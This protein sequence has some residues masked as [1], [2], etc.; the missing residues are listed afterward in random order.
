MSVAI[1]KGAG[2]LLPDALDGSVFRTGQTPGEACARAGASLSDSAPNRRS[3]GFRVALALLLPVF[4]FFCVWIPGGWGDAAGQQIGKSSI[5]EITCSSDE[6][7]ARVVV[8]LDRRVSYRVGRLGADPQ[9]GKPPRIYV[10]MEETLC[11]PSLTTPYEFEVGP[12]ERVRA[13][14]FDPKTSRMVLDLRQM[15]D[16]KVVGMTDPDRIVVD[17]WRIKDHEPE[18]APPNEVPRQRGEARSEPARRMP[19]VVLD[20]GHGGHDP[21]AVGPRGLEEK[22][23]VLD[24][25]KRVRR[26]LRQRG[27]VIVHLTRESDHFLSLDDRTKFANARGADLFVSIHANAAPT[28]GASGVETFYLDNTTDRAAIRLAA[29]ENRTAPKKMSDLQMILRDLEQTAKVM[30]SHALAHRV[31]RSL[32]DGL[33]SDELALRDL[34]VKGNLF[35]VLMGARMPSVLVEV[36]FITNPREERLLRS[37]AYREKAARGIADGILG[38]LQEMESPGLVARQ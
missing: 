4:L 17:V 32:L 33:Q 19:V 24:I 22:T 13:A 28:S 7:H 29:F 23:V 16:Y 20:P 27:N 15:G 14:L 21:G 30:E 35:Y 31:H 1:W 2:N 25:S 38:F 6:G 18:S 5:Q 8:H 11:P 3:Q 37:E 36:S 12:V 34:G 26:I 10:D 9:A